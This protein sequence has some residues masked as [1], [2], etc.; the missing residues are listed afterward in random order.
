[1]RGFTVEH[2][3]GLLERP[4]PL[5]ILD[6]RSDEAFAAGHLP[7]SGHVPAPLLLRR[8]AELPPR[9]RAVLVV[10]ASA[11]EAA[12]VAR[13]LGTMGFADVSWLEA[14]VTALPEARALTPARRLWEPNGFLA[15]RLAGIPPGRALDVASGAG[16]DAV[17][18]ALH[19]FDV[20]AWDRDADALARAGDLARRHGVALRT[21]RCDLEADDVRLP[22]SVFA[23]VVCFRFLHRPLWP[24]LARALAPGGH[25]VYETYR[26]GQERHGRPRRPRFLLEPGELRVAFPGLEVLAWEEPSPAGGPVTSRLHARRPA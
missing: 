23:L 17:F 14:P 1:M 21:C 8:R 12:E 3:A 10:G 5:S 4:D 19:G 2:I 9:H 15:G 11:V 16:R 24:V 18:L 20:E 13:H 22:E 6:V 26:R 25:L 7:G